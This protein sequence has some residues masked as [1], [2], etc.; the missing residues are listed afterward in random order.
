MYGS[1]D[2]SN[3]SNTEGLFLED[4]LGSTDV[5]VLGS[6]EVIKLESS[7]VKVLANVLGKVYGTTLGIAI[8]TKLGSL[9]GYIDGSD[10]G[11][12]EG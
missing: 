11:S 12:L 6:Y 7:Y 9:D 10:Y 8:G 2:G 4:S 5:K 3:G 1:F